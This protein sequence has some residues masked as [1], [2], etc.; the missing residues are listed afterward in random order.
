M[1]REPHPSDIWFEV[2]EYLGSDKL[3]AETMSEIIDC[4]ISRAALNQRRGNTP[5]TI[6]IPV[7]FARQIAAALLAVRKGPGRPPLSWLQHRQYDRRIEEAKEYVDA[8][9]TAGKSRTT[10]EEKAAEIVR[11]YGYRARSIASIRRDLQR[12][13]GSRRYRR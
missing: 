2:A 1:T 13:A 9:V 4:Q 12:A 7:L 10:A 6:E 5:Q 8:L 3:V 11:E